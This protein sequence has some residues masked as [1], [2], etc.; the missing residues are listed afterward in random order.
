[1]LSRTFRKP[2]KF[3]DL[4]KHQKLSRDRATHANAE[5][6]VDNQFSLN[7]LVLPIRRKK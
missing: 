3:Q 6:N 7:D 4:T 2:I 5:A 1:M